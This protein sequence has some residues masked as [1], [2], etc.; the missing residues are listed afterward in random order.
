MWRGRQSEPGRQQETDE[1]L[2]GAGRFRPL[3][4]IDPE[5]L[6]KTGSDRSH[7]TWGGGTQHQNW[8]LGHRVSTPLANLTV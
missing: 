3:A 6:A 2:D 5:A 1:T 8:R 7:S 4:R